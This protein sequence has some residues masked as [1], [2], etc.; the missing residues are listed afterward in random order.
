MSEYKAPSLTAPLTIQLA[1][2]MLSCVWNLAGIYFLSRGLAALGPTASLTTV[3]L[4]VVIGLLMVI[5]AKKK[6][7]LYVISSSIAIAGAS[8]AI[9]GAFIHEPSLWPS[10]FW[11]YAGISLNCLALIGGFWGFTKLYIATER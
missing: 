6:P 1:H 10:E 7:Y 11:R 2:L 3:A 8:S 5:G 4:L 9:V